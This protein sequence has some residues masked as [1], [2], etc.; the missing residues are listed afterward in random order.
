[1]PD[2][3]IFINSHPIQYFAPLYQYLREHGESIEV[4]YCSNEN[5]KGHNDKQFATRVQ[6][7]IPLLEGYSFRF[8]NNWSFNPSIYGGFMGLF[9]PGLLL[10]LFRAPKSIV[11]IHGW[12]YLTH[13]L[14]IIIARLSGHYVCIRGESPMNQE[15]LNPTWKRRLKKMLLGRVLFSFVSKFLYIG[16][17]NYLFYRYMG[18]A[19]EKLKFVPYAVDNKRFRE[20]SVKLK[21]SKPSLRD[22]INIPHQATVILFV[23]KF[24]QKKRPFDILAAFGMLGPSNYALLMVGDG[25]LRGDMELYIKE[26]GLQNV[27]LTG[28]KNQTELPAYYSVAD[29]LVLCSGRGETW[30]LVANEAMNFGL[31]LIVSETVGCAKDLVNPGINGLLYPEGDIKALASA[32]K[33]GQFL[34]GMIG[35]EMLERYS[36]EYINQML[37]T[38]KP[39]SAK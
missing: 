25:E 33:A 34:N 13:A 10:S 7:D 21:P 16:R 39:V 17:E 29:M 12:A 6:W 36:F 9:N 15:L 24:I 18:V 8:F 35:I 14:A 38:L 26:Q 5:V 19:D 32:I 4:W 1:M 28:F 23:G 2:Q 30:G 22:T 31:P 37:R 11:V 27:Y 20:A 3:Y